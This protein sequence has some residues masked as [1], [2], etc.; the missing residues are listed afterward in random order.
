[1]IVT[2]KKGASIYF[3]FI[4]PL[5]LPL[6][7][8]DYA[9]FKIIISFLFEMETEMKETGNPYEKKSDTDTGEVSMS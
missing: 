7:I 1:M 5:E 2:I 9:P 6:E 4:K 8:F 3:F